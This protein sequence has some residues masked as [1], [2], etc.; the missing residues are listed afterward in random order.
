MGLQMTSYHGFI[1]GFVILSG[2]T[3]ARI[4]FGQPTGWQGSLT[5]FGSNGSASSTNSLVEFG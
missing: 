5:W 1:S 3:L 2:L 4:E